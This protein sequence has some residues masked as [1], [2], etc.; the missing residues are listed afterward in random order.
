MTEII[1]KGQKMGEIRPELDPDKTAGLLL[2]VME[3]AVL[4]DKTSQSQ[5]EISNAIEFI[6]NYLKR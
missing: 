4:L 3:G 1:K 5:T 2:G 6:G